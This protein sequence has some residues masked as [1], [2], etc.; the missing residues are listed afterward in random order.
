LLS[1]MPMLPPASVITSM[2]L[3]AFSV[4]ASVAAASV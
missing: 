4:S 3:P 1:V 2:F